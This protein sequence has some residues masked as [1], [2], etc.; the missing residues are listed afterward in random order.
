MLRA[1]RESLWGAIS[2]AANVPERF[3]CGV[4]ARVALG[5]LVRGSSLS[6]RSEELRGRSVLVATRNQLAAAL[7][8]IE[9][10]GV[11]RRLVLC[12]PDMAIE[13]VRF[14][15][16]STETDAIVSDE[17]S[18]AEGC[19][20][21]RSFIPCSAKIVSSNCDRS[22]RQPTEWVLLTSG[23]TG[24]P[25]MVVHTLSSLA[26]AIK[27]LGVAADAPV[28][29]TFYD[30]RRYG[31][32][33]IFLR[34]LLA[35]GSLV[36]SSAGEPAAEFLNRAGAHGVTHISGTPSHWRGA[37]M[38]PSASRISPQVIR[39]SGEIADQSIID[40][41]RS[42]YPQAK[43]GHAF[44]STEA[45]VAFE[46]ND[47]LAGF[48]ARIVGQ[49]GGDVEMKLEGGSLRIRSTRLATHYIGH[50]SK[51]LREADGFVDTGDMLELRGDRYYFAGRRDGTI[52]V[53][54]LKVHPEEVEAVINRHPQVRMSLVRAR[55]NSITGAL[56]V[57][58]VV[59]ERDTHAAIQRNDDLQ[60]EILQ[61][62]RNLL[63]RHKV[64]AAINVVPALAVAATGKMVRRHA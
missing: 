34:A 42:F 61:L 29:S 39:L 50:E 16:A 58:D 33:Q 63:P 49:P 59:I 47:G 12:P 14:V 18:V 52:N 9:L 11:A 41:L 54:G 5:D 37:L 44:A 62:C 64:P 51:A 8:L 1:D 40:H 23:T 20:E 45:G 27:D 36:L 31:G 21:I 19:P 6:G 53:G 3:L 28:W 30:I 25:K 57:A 7:A 24:M 38:S 26:G 4:D 43:V 48:P 22:I 55:K 2:S 46:V 10:D 35:G 32:L 60:H 13:H 15:A 17:A 56:V